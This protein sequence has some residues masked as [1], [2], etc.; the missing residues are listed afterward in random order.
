MKFIRLIIFSICLI[1]AVL[2]LDAQSKIYPF[3]EGIPSSQVY[4]VKIDGKKAF[5]YDAPVAPLVSFDMEGP[6]NVELKADREVFWVDIRP[7]ILGIVPEFKDSTIRFTL[8]KPCSISIELNGEFSNKP[9]LLFANPVEKDC[10]KQGD[11]GVLFFEA[12]KVYTP[13]KIDLKSNEQVYIEGGAIVFG[14]IKANDATNIKISGR[15]ILDGTKNSELNKGSDRHFIGFTNCKNIQLE[16]ITLVNSL[17]WQVVPAHCEDVTIHNIKIVS[18]N[19]SDDGIDLVRSRKVRIEGCFIHTK[20]D[21]IAIKSHM[22]YPGKEGNEDI[23]VSNSVFWNTEWGNALEIGFELRAD[24]MKNISFRN[25]D[26]IHCD[27][28]AVFSIHNGDRSV[29]KDILFDNIRVEDARQKLFDLAIFLTQY[30]VDS[31]KDAA[32]RKLRYQNGPWDGTMHQTK[33][34]KIAQAPFRGY[35]RNITFRDIQVTDGIFPFSVFCGY[36]ENHLIENITI[37]NL[38]V[39]GKKIQSEKEARLST[40]FCKSIVIR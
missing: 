32:E 23:L 30:S 28:G 14:S 3:P 1:F 13:G 40:R 4:D 27:D 34:Q 17:S 22:N 12:G 39:H 37:E 20:D 5:V 24:T 19:G 15:G 9:L 8:D 7:K 38:V 10:P 6:V 35:I 29:V 31:P 16:G 36:D 2:R 21:C 26:I 25:C 11:Q 18:N 33:E